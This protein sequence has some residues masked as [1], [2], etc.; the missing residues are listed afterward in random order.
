MMKKS[1][2][3]GC[4]AALFCVSATV[5]GANVVTDWSE[6]AEEA[7]V[8]T[9][10]KAPAASAIN[11]AMVHIA[12]YD[13]VNTICPS[14]FS[15]FAVTTTPHPGAS[16][17]AA[18]AAAAHGVLVGMFPDQQPNL[19]TI[20]AA[21]LA[22]IPDDL[23][24]ADGIAVGDEVASGVL[25]LRSNDNRDSQYLY[26]QPNGA[27]V[28]QP[29]AAPVGIELP[30]V[31]PFALTSASQF[32]PSGPPPLRSAKYARDLLEVEEI[33]RSDSEIRTDSQ[34][35][36]A[37]FLT[38]H[39]QLQLNRAFRRLA[40]EQELDIVDTARMFAMVHAATADSSIACYEAK[41]FYNFWRPIQAI[42]HANEDANKRTEPD[43]SWLPLIP[44]PSHPEFPSSHACHTSAAMLALRKFFRADYVPFTVDS[45]VTVTTQVY[46]AF[47]EFTADVIEGRI[48]GGIHFRFSMEAAAKLGR[49]TTQ[50]MLC[51][52]FQRVDASARVC[53]D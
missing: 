3:L 35:E 51:K 31:T 16:L 47:S 15:N 36:T 38:E 21:A 20:Y 43:P 9:A 14:G 40:T 1:L 53:S 6:V 7:I 26:S 49:A 37:R 12:I 33:G 39:T 25:A 18:V 46:N 2:R 52:R 24:K 29:T 5:A 8:R 30:H 11:M 45:T 32:R 48:W 19:D 10:R 27:G 44:T 28:W 41:Y 50:W 22:V 4:L 23:A 34:T 42:P 17:E 13:A